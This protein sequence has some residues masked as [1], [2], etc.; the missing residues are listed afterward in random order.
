MTNLLKEIPAAKRKPSDASA[1]YHAA[2]YCHSMQLRLPIKL[3]PGHATLSLCRASLRIDM[4]TF[5]E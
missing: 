5:H 3:S 4:N 2:R 1:R